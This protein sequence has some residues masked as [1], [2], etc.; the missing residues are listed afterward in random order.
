[1]VEDEPCPVLITTVASVGAACVHVK[2]PGRLGGF[3]LL[4]RQIHLLFAGRVR[5]PRWRITRSV[6]RIPQSLRSSVH[7]RFRVA[8]PSG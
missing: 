4:L 3:P 2:P 1:M 6:W 8:A 7:G 5:P